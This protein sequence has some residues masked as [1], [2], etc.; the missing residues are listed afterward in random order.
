MKHLVTGL[1]C[2]LALGSAVRAADITLLNV[3]STR[4]VGSMR[5]C[6]KLSPQPTNVRWQFCFLEALPTRAPAAKLCL[7]LDAPFCAG[8]APISLSR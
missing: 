2:T 5:L 4:R 7:F 1:I 8:F 3:S 6:A